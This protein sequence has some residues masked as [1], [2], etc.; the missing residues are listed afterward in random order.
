MRTEDEKRST[1]KDPRGD[2]GEVR[3]T[4]PDSGAWEDTHSTSEGSVPEMENQPTESQDELNSQELQQIVLMCGSK[5]GFATYM[6]YDAT[7][8]VESWKVHNLKTPVEYLRSRHDFDVLSVIA[9]TGSLA[10][11]AEWYGVSEATLKGN[12]KKL[13]GYRSTLPVKL[14]P[15]LVKFAMVRYKS[16]RLS[17]RMLE[18]S[19]GDVRQLAKEAGMDLSKVVDA[20]VTDFSNGFGRRAEV[21]FMGNC[22]EDEVLEDMNKTQGPNALFDVRHAILGRVNVKASCRYRFKGKSRKK[23][24]PYYWKFSTRGLREADCLVCMC[25]SDDG[26]TLIKQV[27]IATASIKDCKSFSMWGTCDGLPTGV[28]A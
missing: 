9:R 11:T 24:Y 28:I 12:L 23:T 20:S 21:E 14:S 19:E 6:R 5:G 26:K 1:E 27:V 16:V 18:S 15:D 3:Q 25:Y 8:L 10:R 4:H 7:Q 22:L 13:S 17:A 2:G